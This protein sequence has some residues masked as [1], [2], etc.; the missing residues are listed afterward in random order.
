MFFAELKINAKT[1]LIVSVEATTMSSA[2]ARVKDMIAG[3]ALAAP[4]STIE[5]LGI[6]Q[7]KPRKW[8][9]VSLTESDL[10][11]FAI[12]DSNLETEERQRNEEKA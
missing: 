6:G 4:T 1:L 7:K 9:T 10:R 8:A 11:N 12:D 5:V 2:L 3:F